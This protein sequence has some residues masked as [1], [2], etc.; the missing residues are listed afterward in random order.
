LNRVVEIA[1]IPLHKEKSPVSRALPLQGVRYKLHP[2]LSEANGRPALA[3]IPMIATS[4][5]DHL[6]KITRLT[7]LTSVDE[8]VIIKN[9]PGISY[10]LLA[11]D[12][13]GLFGSR[14]NESIIPW[15]FLFESVAAI[16]TLIGFEAEEMNEFTLKVEYPATLSG[17][18]CNTY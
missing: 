5:A 6:P 18:I 3:V 8:K 16:S 10:T 15:D 7:E 1:P 4:I 11:D 13:A 17:P 14:T 9:L 2:F 12:V